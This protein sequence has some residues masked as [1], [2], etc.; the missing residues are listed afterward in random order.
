MEKKSPVQFWT[1]NSKKITI[2]MIVLLTIVIDKVFLKDIIYGNDL[3]QSKVY[4]GV[5]ISIGIIL[6]HDIQKILNDFLKNKIK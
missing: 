4:Q 1:D 3:M 5:L 2:T 6:T